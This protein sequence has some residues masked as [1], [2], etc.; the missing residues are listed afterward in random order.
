MLDIFRRKLKMAF[1]NGPFQGI[2][3]GGQNF[4]EPKLSQMNKVK[5]FFFLSSFLMETR[6]FFLNSG[7]KNN[8]YNTGQLDSYNL[9]KKDRALSFNA[10]SLNWDLLG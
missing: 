10:A 4:F 7:I 3:R 6:I 5:K 2:F 8:F 9:N 1:S